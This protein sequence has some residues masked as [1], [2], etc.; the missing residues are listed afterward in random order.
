MHCDREQLVA[1]LRQDHEYMAELMAQIRRLC[2]RGDAA[3]NCN[4]CPVDRRTLCNSD[5]VQLMRVFV[6]ATLRHHLIESA[7]M[8]EEVPRAH[9]VAHNRAHITIAEQM[10][11]IRRAFGETGNGVVAVA[12]IAALLDTLA[13]HYADFDRPLEDYLLAA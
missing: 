3:E 13:T 7:C 8:A 9:R 12:D 2:V 5:I 10:E 11:G 1:K 6:E 4:G